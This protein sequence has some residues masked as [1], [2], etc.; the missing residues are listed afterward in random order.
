MKFTIF[1]IFCFIF[2][3]I[4]AHQNESFGF[5]SE[6]IHRDSPLSPFSDFN[7]SNV[8][9][10]GIAF[11]RILQ[12]YQTQQ[13][14]S[15]ILIFNDFSYLMKIWYGNPPVEFFQIV[16]TG[17]DL[18]WIQC[19]PCVHC[20]PSQHSP[21]PPKISN[22]FVYETCPQTKNKRCP[23]NTNYG[24]HSYSQGELARESIRLGPGPHKV[25]IDHFLFGCGYNNIGKFAPKGAGIVGFNP[26]P[27]SFVSQLS[28]KHHGKFAYCMPPPTSQRPGKISFGTEAVV[29]GN[30][31]MK[32]PLIIDS[33]Y[34]VMLE[35]ITVATKKINYLPDQ[36]SSKNL[37]GIK[38]GRMLID[39]GT[40]MM[41]LPPPLQEHILAQVSDHI[42]AKPIA[43]PPAP[44]TLCYP[45]SLKDSEIPNIIVHFTGAELVLSPLH[46][47]MPTISRD[48]CLAIIP[49]H[50]LPVLGNM[51]QVNFLVGFNIV[52]KKLA[53]KPT[54]C[55]SLKI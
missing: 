37:T 29:K 22:T 35:G 18:P 53:F 16:D 3:S 45:A 51:A 1:F 30:G 46:T 23:Y 10:Q 55:S 41:I 7:L 12:R 9:R 25:K 34:Y 6:L 27:R 36:Y 19:E 49:Q 47:F 52:K 14:G 54:D 20:F 39:S 40:N 33:Q 11:Q 31:V 17:S 50:R 43:R 38:G 2:I 13:E 42:K 15:S 4:E 28:W 24:D 44:F 32:T 8:Q 48:R 26:Q 5:S 21:Y